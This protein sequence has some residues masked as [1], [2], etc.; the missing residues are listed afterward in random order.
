MKVALFFLQPEGRSPDGVV[1]AMYGRFNLGGFMFI[2]L[3]D[4]NIFM[5]MQ[6]STYG[7]FRWKGGSIL[8]GAYEC[9]MISVDE[10]EK[11]RILATCEACVKVKKP[12]NLRDLVLMH[13]PFR[14]VEDLSIDQAPTLNNA[15][16]MILILRECLNPDNRLREGIDGLHSRQTLLEELFNRVRPLAVPVTAANIAALVCWEV[17]DLQGNPVQQH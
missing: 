14:E 12:F 10:E 9:L 1:H 6:G 16:A 17:D 4:I 11:Y 13:I 3:T 2:D 7:K 15:Q 8:H 5:T